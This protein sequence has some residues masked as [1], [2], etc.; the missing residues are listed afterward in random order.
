MC[1]AFDNT[2]HLLLSN[3]KSIILK[4]CRLYNVFGSRLSHGIYALFIS[5]ATEANGGKSIGLLQGAG[6]RFVF[7]FYAMHHALCL[8][9]ALLA[10]IHNPSFAGLHILKN[11]D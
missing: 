5:H 4:V 1:Y 11:N 8:K 7:F 9:G 2:N 10:T 3:L 6:N